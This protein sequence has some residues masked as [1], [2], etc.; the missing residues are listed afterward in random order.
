MGITE[1]NDHR[2]RSLLAGQLGRAALTQGP[3]PV[4]TFDPLSDPR[5]TSFLWSHPGSSVFHTRPWLSALRRTYCYQPIAFTTYAPHEELRNAAVFCLV[6][7]WLT[8]RRPVSLPFS[9]HCDVLVDAEPDLESILSALVEERRKRKL[10]YIEF[11][12]SRP[13]DLLA[14]LSRGTHS[15][16]SYCLHRLDLT[17]SL[18]TLFRNLHKNSTQRK[19]RRSERECLTYQEGQ[20][21]SLLEAFNRLWVVTRRRH[22]TP[23][24]PVKWFRN[25]IEYFGKA[26]K[27][28]VAFKDGQPIAAIISLQY[29]DGLVYKYGCS[30]ARF[31]RFGGMHLLLWKSI[32]AAKWD[33][34]RHFDLGRSDWK[35]AGLVTFKDRWSASRSALTYWKIGESPS[36]NRTHL[37]KKTDWKER[38]V[39]SVSGHLP[40][41]VFRSL[42]TLIY[43]H[44]G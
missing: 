41:R 17:P 36:A 8:G 39:R 20:S 6:D 32:Q 23:P 1:N 10:S 25:L 22:R 12:E 19:I 35:D 29:K 38:I 34:L 16:V 18:D 2:V 27:I 5:W 9:D 42:G 30:D 31:H 15:G 4:Y 33:G 28:R 26:L 13:V 37:P 3:Q 7:S 21:E 14:T 43:R 24:Q 40:D 44:I 11:R